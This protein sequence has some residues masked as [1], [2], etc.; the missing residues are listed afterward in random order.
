[1]TPPIPRKN[2][3]PE[4]TGVW[5]R[6]RTSCPN[7]FVHL[8]TIPT[9]KYPL[10]LVAV[11]IGFL[12]APH[13]QGQTGSAQKP[14]RI[15]FLC[16]FTGGSQ[17]F[18]NSAR[19]GAELA[20]KEINEVN[21]YLG[22]PV[23]LVARD[24]K[25]NP[26]E[27]RRV[28]EELVLREKVN[29]TVGF[30]NTGVAMKSLD[31]FQDNKH[32]LVS[33]VTGSALNEKYPAA[34]SYIFRMS[35]RDT[36]QAQALVEE[37]VVRRGM[38][39]VAVFADNTG[40]GS[41]GAKDVQK[42]LA[43]KGLTP[44]YV[45][46]FD[47]GV[48]SLVDKIKEA[49]AAGAMAI[50]GYTV[51]SEFAVMVKSRAEAGF[52]GPLYG[53]WPLSIRSVAEKAGAAAEGVSMVQ[54]IIQDLSN[55]RRATFIARLR[56]HAGT[57]PIASLMTAAQVYDAIFLMLHATFQAKGD[58][59]GDALKRALENLDRSYQGVITT[60]DKPFLSTDHEAFTA[61]MIWLG[62]WRNGEIQ[63]LYKDDAKLASYVKR[64]QK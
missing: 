45:G 2:W 20:V 10:F 59:S 34:Q 64:K 35:A 3:L 44:V 1:M 33:V 24:D 40:Y 31:I 15:G 52:S 37:V 48:T 6:L 23:E 54:T 5:N 58:T 38:T 43:D 46:R 13:A 18:G 27:G 63:F 4:K 36:L 25:G 56:R 26:D 51:G 16:P 21:G 60:H 49:K 7:F 32:L 28:A 47:L 22:R 9:M 11:C 53:S 62:T 55:E 29:F 57:Q 30:C 61:N 14:I 19:L 12:W 17:D 41:G 50:I 42:F 39:K 8:Y